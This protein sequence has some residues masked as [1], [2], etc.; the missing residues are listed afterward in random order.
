MTRK[1]SQP[2]GLAGVSTPVR[3]QAVLYPALSVDKS[4]QHASWNPQSLTRFRELEMTVL[5]IHEDTS[6]TLPCL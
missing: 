6:I 5:A 3:L 1:K 4:L 2:H